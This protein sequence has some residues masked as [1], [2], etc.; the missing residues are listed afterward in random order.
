[1]RHLIKS[2]LSVLV[3]PALVA[4]LIAG[5]TRAEEVKVGDLVITQAWSRATPKGAKIA[6]GYL[7]IE[8][9]GSASDRMVGVSSDIAGKVDVH[10]MAMNNGVMK[11]RPLDQGLTVEAGKTVKL[12]PGGRHLML[13]DLS[14]PL[15]QGD[16]VPIALQFEKA[17]KVTVSLAVQ[18]VGA[19]GPSSAQRSDDPVQLKTAPDHSGMKMSSPG[20]DEN[21]FTHIHTEKVM[22]NVTVSPGR[23]GPVDLTIQLETTDE[24]PLLA[25]AVSVALSNDESGIRLQPMR[26]VRTSDNLWQVRISM[27]GSGRWSLGLG[28]SISETNQVNV[29]APILIR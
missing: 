25:K 12:A 14:S 22:A 24:L 28:I 15:L 7:T 4:V 10:E 8:N 6:G 29:E 16:S 21:F 5:P 26:A 17:G 1:M 2:S 13:M 27:L 9:K 23:V 18:G 20:D 3:G 11:M 19:Q